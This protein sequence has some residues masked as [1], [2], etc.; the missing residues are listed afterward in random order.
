MR[1]SWGR[2]EWVGFKLSSSTI[3]TITNVGVKEV[4]EIRKKGYL[5]FGSI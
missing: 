5:G 3:S 1:D 2:Q 4:E